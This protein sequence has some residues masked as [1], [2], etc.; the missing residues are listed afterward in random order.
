MSIIRCFRTTLA[1]SALDSAAEKNS[2]IERHEKEEPGLKTPLLPPHRSVGTAP[3]AD[4]VMP[5]RQ[6]SCPADPKSSYCPYYGWA[7]ER[8]SIRKPLCKT[9]QSNFQ[10]KVT[11]PA[12][13][14]KGPNG[15]VNGEAEN[16]TPEAGSLK[17]LWCFPVIMQ[18]WS[19]MMYFYIPGMQTFLVKDFTGKGRHS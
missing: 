15:R 16:Q 5:R 1:S 14:R 9:K 18:L 13:G 8:V 10:I 7:D 12:E 19:C 17:S 4:A 11:A 2:V 3:V 6:A